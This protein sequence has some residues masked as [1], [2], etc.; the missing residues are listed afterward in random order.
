M[1][2][3]ER[4]D[5]MERQLTAARR[6]VDGDH[7][8]PEAELP[9]ADGPLPQPLVDR[10][11]AILAA[12]RQAEVAVA[13]AMALVGERLARLSAARHVR[14]ALAERTAPSYVDTRA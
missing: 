8:V 9:P 2:W 7:I 10:A 11:T 13:D 1:A 6:A 5:A 4:L 12:T 14:S 3:P